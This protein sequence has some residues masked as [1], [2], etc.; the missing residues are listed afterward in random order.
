MR[1]AAAARAGGSGVTHAIGA[2][3]LTGD[4]PTPTDTATP[5]FDAV[6]AMFPGALCGVTPRRDPALTTT[7]PD[8]A[9]EGPR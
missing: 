9:L 1:P 6:A 5:I 8:G 7:T 2:G 4:L 3:E